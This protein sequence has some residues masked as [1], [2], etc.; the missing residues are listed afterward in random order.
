MKLGKNKNKLIAFTLATLFVATGTYNAVVINSESQLS[1]A[2]VKFVKRLDEIYGVTV[3]GREV[4][5][6]VTWQKLG[7]SK[8]AKRQKEE[9][10]QAVKVVN[11]APEASASDESIPAA[12]VQEDLTLSLVEVINPKKWEKGLPNTQFAGSLTANNGVIEEL[13]VSLP[14]GE[15]VAVSFS[16][17]TGNVFEYDMNGELYS[18]MMYQVDQYAYM[19][20]LTNGPLEG[21]RL[22]FSTQS[23]EVIQQETQAYLADNNNVEVGSF[24]NNAEQFGNTDAAYAEAQ[25]VNPEQMIENDKAMQIQAEQ[26]QSF[27]FDQNPAM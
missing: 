26:A 11:S 17:M 8:I 1:G 9:I 27:N 4:A 6:S 15:G 19:V 7:P 18:G 13:N 16:E 14:N 2:E 5:A 12:A 20:T 10:T 24:G 22:R 21:T 25:G 3:P 23:T